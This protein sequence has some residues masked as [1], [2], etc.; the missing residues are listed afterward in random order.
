VVADHALGD[1]LRPYGSR[2]LSVRTWVAVGLAALPLLAGCG[3]E[4]SNDADHPAAP[5]TGLEQAT[6]RGLA[7][8]VMA[9]IE[10]GEVTSVS[11]GGEGDTLHVD[12]GT[13]GREVTSVFVS[14][15]EPYAGSPACGTDIGFEQVDCTAGPP[16]SEVVE[17]KRLG[18][19]TPVYIGRAQSEGRGHVI[20]EVFGEPSDE[21]L[22]LVRALVADPLIGLETTG[23]LNSHGDEIDDFGD[24]ELTIELET[25]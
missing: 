15:I 11:G 4:P 19:R 2:V 16:F 12:L 8:S 17:K 23:A 10:S 25:R 13:T 14:V 22:A 20:V 3:S 24:L 1:D 5:S 9:H 21:G 6:S 18:P 7:A